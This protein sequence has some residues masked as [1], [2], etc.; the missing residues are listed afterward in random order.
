VKILVERDIFGDNYTTSRVFID[1]RFFCYCLE[2]TDRK[3]EDNPEAKVYGETAIPRGTYKL[4]VDFS[5]R[6]QREL[7]RLLDVPGYSGI[8]I[9]AGNVPAD[10]HGCLLLGTSRKD[11]MVV[12]SRIAMVKFMELL[13]L[14]YDRGEQVEVTIE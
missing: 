11:G 7:P 5:G 4:L 12:N 10:T 2:D 14:A 1:G 8:R 6:F 3:L 13:D 9:H